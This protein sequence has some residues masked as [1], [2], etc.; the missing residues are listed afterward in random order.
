MFPFCDSML[1]Y[2]RASFNVQKW[3]FHEELPLRRK[4]GLCNCHSLTGHQ[5]TNPLSQHEK[6][7][8]G[9]LFK[10]PKCLR[11]MTTKTFWPVLCKAP[12]NV[13]SPGAPRVSGAYR[14]S[15][16]VCDDARL[17]NAVLIEHNAEYNDAGT[18]AWLCCPAMC[19]LV[20]LILSLEVFAAFIVI[21]TQAASA[22]RFN[23]FWCK[24]APYL[25][26]PNDI[27]GRLD[28][29]YGAVLT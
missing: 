18:W 5:T 4:R 28:L 17:H 11:A 20:S 25:A 21:L 8:E 7:I 16:G 24:S 13:T 2:S 1:V 29:M 14:V 27:Q 10:K 3:K 12:S 22:R 9:I 26:V 6:N 19:F 23:V 15:D